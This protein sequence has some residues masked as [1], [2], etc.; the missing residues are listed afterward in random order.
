LKSDVF[1]KI[2]G[3]VLVVDSAP[4]HPVRT[5]GTRLAN[6]KNCKADVAAWLR[7]LECVAQ[8]WE[9]THREK[10]KLKKVPFEQAATN[11]PAPMYFARDL[12]KY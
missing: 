8:E 11:H 6:T 9:G 1:L 10:D 12:E 5:E 3:G 4:Y 2:R 7:A